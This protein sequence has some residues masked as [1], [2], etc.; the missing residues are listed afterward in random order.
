MLVINTKPGRIPYIKTQACVPPIQLIEDK[1]TLSERCD[2]LHLEL[3]NRERKYQESIRNME[4]RSKMVLYL[5][6]H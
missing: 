4:Q 6:H 2:H 1:R 5:L 3:K